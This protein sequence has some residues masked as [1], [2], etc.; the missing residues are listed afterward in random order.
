MDKTTSRTTRVLATISERLFYALAALAT[1]L[2][3]VSWFARDSEVIVPALVILCGIIGAFVGLQRRLKGLTFE[4]LELLEFSWLQICLS[5]LVGGILAMLLYILM[6]GDFLHS[7]LL[8]VFVGDGEKGVG[9]FIAIFRQHAVGYQDYAK[10]FV[11]SFI[12]GYSEHFVTDVLGRF[13]GQAVGK[14]SQDE[15]RLER[16]PTEV[17]RDDLDR[18][19]R[20]VPADGN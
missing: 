18:R 9:R 19:P 11:W 6:L 4:D 13:E 2:L 3:T 14:R 8:P 10:L 5:P 20:A 15:L 16:Q 17:N 12:A 7:P 1:I